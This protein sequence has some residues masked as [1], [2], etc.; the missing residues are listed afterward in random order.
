M[1]KYGYGI[2][3]FEVGDI[4]TLDGSLEN[5][6]DLTQVIY[7]DTITLDEPEPTETNHFVEGQKYPVVSID[8][9]GAAKIMANLFGATPAEKVALMGG[10]VTTVADVDSYNSPSENV[11]IEKYLKITLKSGHII[12][13]PRVKV[14]GRH[15]GEI[16][17]GGVLITPV[18]FTVLAPNFAALKPMILTDPA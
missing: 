4:A 15:T 8:Q 1:G 5:E 6:V 11:A 13:F 7:K 17:E 18:K 14:S 2:S 3:K 16:K 10:T 9:A 12:Q